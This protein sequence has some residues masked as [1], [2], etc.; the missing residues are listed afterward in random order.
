MPIQE[1]HIIN[2]ITHILCIPKICH[3]GFQMCTI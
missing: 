2:P 3:T 1:A